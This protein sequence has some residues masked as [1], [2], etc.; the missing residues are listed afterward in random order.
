MNITLSHHDHHTIE[1]RYSSVDTET[2][3]HESEFNCGEGQ[4]IF[5][6]STVSRLA[7]GP[8]QPPVKWVQ[9]FFPRR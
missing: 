5:V 1:K 2:G 7:L 4:E 9:W 8:T 6:I 3:Y